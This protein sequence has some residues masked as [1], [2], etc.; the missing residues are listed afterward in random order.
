MT[1]QT[2][3]VIGGAGAQGEPIVEGAHLAYLDQDSELTEY[4]PPQT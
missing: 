1:S 4:S 3:L 2:V